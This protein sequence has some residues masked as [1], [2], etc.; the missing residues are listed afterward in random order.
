MKGIIRKLLLAA[1]SLSLIACGS[2]GGSSAGASSSGGGSSSDTLHFELKTGILDYADYEYVGKGFYAGGSGDPEKTVCFNFNYTNL[3]SDPKSYYQD[4]WVNAYQNGTELDTASGYS[5]SNAPETVENTSKTVLQNGTIKV[6]VVYVLQDDSPVTIIAKHNGGSEKSNQLILT[7]EP[8]QDNSFDMNRI[9]GYWEGKD[10]TSLTIT[11]SK[12]TLKY[13]KSSSTYRDNPN[14]WT[15]A[16]NLH[17]DV[18][19]ID[20]LRIEEKDGTLHLINETYDF[21]QTE[22]WPEG[23]GGTEL[24]TA[25]LGETITTEFAELSF[26][27]SGHKPELKYSN[28]TGGSE[29]SYG[30]H[31]TFSLIVGRETPGKEHL[32]LEGTIKNT[33][34][35]DYDP[36][37]MKVKAVINGTTELEGDVTALSGGKSLSSLNPMNSATIVLHTEMDSSLVNDISS[38]EWYFG[39]DRN[40]SGSSKGDPSESR[41]YY[42]IKA[43]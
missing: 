25:E 12:V 19:E 41:Y 13:S 8:Y 24:K 23:E 22:N 1:A 38:L 27:E 14:L 2:S 43:K 6:G 33:S 20:P 31:I 18:S 3:D 4:F 11:S 7:L 9:Y 21:T 26:T 40:F 5:Y 15:D 39:F 35:Q 29:G 10:D 42:V 36:E 28:T 34:S 37:D 30:G 32:Y 16:S 17:P